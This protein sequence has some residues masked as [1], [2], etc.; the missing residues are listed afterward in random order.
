MCG[1]MINPV[2]SR[3]PWNVNDTEL[4]ELRLVSIL[5]MILNIGIKYRL[6]RCLLS[7]NH[8]DKHYS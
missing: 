2:E 4:L 3:T 7:R 8:I 5:E 6:N 1:R